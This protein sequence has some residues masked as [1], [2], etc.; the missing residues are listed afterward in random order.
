M[1]RKMKSEKTARRGREME[2]DQ[3]VEQE[4]IET[5]EQPEVEQTEEQS[6]E[7]VTEEQQQAAEEARKKAEGIKRFEE[8][9]SRRLKEARLERENEYLKKMVSQQVTPQSTV[10]QQP[11]R[12]DP[13]EP[14]LDNYFAEGRTAEDWSR[15]HRLYIEQE[16]ERSRSIGNTKKQI[17][18]KLNEYAKT[19][20]DIFTYE[21]ALSSMVTPAVAAA[22]INCEQLGGVIETLALD[23]DKVY[24]LN[25]ITDPYKLSREII[26]IEESLRKKPV[27]SGAPR[28][29]E[30]S[31]GKAP[32]SGGVDISAMTSAEYR[33]FRNSQRKR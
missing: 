7:Q 28:S 20:K 31:K 26:K 32:Q 9:E 19:N 23:E 30:V 29:P 25:A 17:D 2:Q 22:I 5:Q 21:N 1:N 6:S 12:Q 24:A 10:P 4:V 18:D 11:R 8:R 15:D 14:K 13:N 33:K 16:I 27:F 3:I